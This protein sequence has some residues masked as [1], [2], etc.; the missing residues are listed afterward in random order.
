MFRYRLRY[1]APDDFIE[2]ASRQIN[3]M[4]LSN[5][6]R[7]GNGAEEDEKGLVLFGPSHPVMNSGLRRS[8]Y[9]DIQMDAQQDLSSL[10]Q[11]LDC[12]G[13]QEYLFTQ[14]GLQLYS[15]TSPEVRSSNASL[16]SGEISLPGH[17]ISEPE[18]WT[19]VGQKGTHRVVVNP[20]AKS[21]SSIAIHEGEFS[22]EQKLQLFATRLVEQ[23][24]CFGEGPRFLMSNID[25][26]AVEF[27]LGTLA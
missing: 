5:H 27:L 13:T 15:T 21:M 16:G 7:A 11:W 3:L 20:E 18:L 2:L 9:Q 17:E 1:E 25:K 6:Q 24:V 4:S 12:Y 14:W 8:I 26:L 19:K 10:K 22:F 23:A